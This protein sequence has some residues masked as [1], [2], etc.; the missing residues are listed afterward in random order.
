MPIRKRWKIGQHLVVDDRTGFVHYA[1]EMRREWNGF[2]V[3]RRIYE[4]RN[5]QEQVRGLKDKQFVEDARPRGIDQFTGPLT[6]ELDGAHTAGTQTINV[7]SSARF[8]GGDHLRIALDNREMFRA[9]VQTIPSATSIELT[10]TLPWA[11]SDGNAVVNITAVSQ[12]DIS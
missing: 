12:S 4:R 1:S 5:P 3:S 11:A 8:S 6:T 7:T 10:A 9:I 2:L